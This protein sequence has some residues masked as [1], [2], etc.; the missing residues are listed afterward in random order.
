MT[1]KL[2]VSD[3][4]VLLQIRYAARNFSSRLL[5]TCSQIAGEDRLICER[6]K[7]T[8][9]I[10]IVSLSLAVPQRVSC[11]SWERSLHEYFC[12]SL[13]VCCS[14]DGFYAFVRWIIACSCLTNEYSCSLHL[15]PGSS[16]SGAPP[17]RAPTAWAAP[18]PSPQ[19]WLA[20]TT[21]SPR[22][23]GVTSQVWSPVGS[24]G[25][26]AAM[27]VW[28]SCRRWGQAGLGTSLWPGCPCPPAWSRRL[29]GTGLGTAHLWCSPAGTR[30]GLCLRGGP[31]PTRR[32]GQKGWGQA[33]QGG[34]GLLVPLGA[35]VENFADFT[36][37]M[38][39]TYLTDVFSF[40]SQ[41]SCLRTISIPLLSIFFKCS[42][43]LM[44]VLIGF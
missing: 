26:T 20:G 12:S 18:C 14:M 34:W 22:G 16:L 35:L 21:N 37:H 29:Q 44:E 6:G 9:H 4:A 24:S 13:P 43:R 8:E 36:A 3:P 38:Y 15:M 42:D 30:S 39:I 33:A 17:V 19:W 31:R 40:N 7:W 2:S 11:R 25:D 28:G 32:H 5:S 23:D 41:N 27:W 1:D 10:L